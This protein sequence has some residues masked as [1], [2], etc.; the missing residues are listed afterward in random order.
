MG[1]HND[2]ADDDDDD[3]DDEDDDDEKYN[4]DDPIVKEES[5]WNGEPVML[6]NYNIKLQFISRLQVVT[7]I[8]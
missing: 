7:Y 5:Y 2:D 6:R 3:D 8:N 1:P 4:D